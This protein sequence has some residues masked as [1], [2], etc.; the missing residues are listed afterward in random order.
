MT[1][2]DQTTPSTDGSKRVVWTGAIN[3]LLTGS[4][5][6]SRINKAIDQSFTQSP[7]LKTN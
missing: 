6:S 7:Y 3:G 2:V 5:S 1:I 4:Y